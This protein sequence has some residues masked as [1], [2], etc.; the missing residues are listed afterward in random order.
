VSEESPTANLEELICRALEAFSRRNWDAA[1][2]FYAPDAVYKSMAMDATFA[3]VPAIRK[4]LEYFVGAYEEFDVQTEENR[5]LGDGMGLAVVKQ[6]GRPAGSGFE[7]RMRYAAVSEWV[8]GLLVRITMYTDI[9]DARAAAER[10][11][12]ERG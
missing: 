2:A 5:D 4:F 7:I 6:R 9:D 10:L 1:F 11:A 3:G 12:E 8:E